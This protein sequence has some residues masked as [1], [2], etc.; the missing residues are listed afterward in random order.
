MCAPEKKTIARQVRDSVELLGIVAVGPGW[1]ILPSSFCSVVCLSA[2]V[3]AGNATSGF[4][5]FF[6]CSVKKQRALFYNA[7]DLFVFAMLMQTL[8]FPY[9]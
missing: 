9:E 4:P 8:W 6:R 7:N 2:P 5:K 3:H 1:I